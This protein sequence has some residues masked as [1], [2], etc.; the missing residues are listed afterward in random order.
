[1]SSI[2]LALPDILLREGQSLAI[3]AEIF[4]SP[5]THNV[6]SS[7]ALIEQCLSALQPL[8]NLKNITLTIGK[9]EE[10]ESYGPG[11]YIQRVMVAMLLYLLNQPCTHLTLSLTHQT[12]IDGASMIIDIDYQGALAFLDIEMPTSPSEFLFL[13]LGLSSMLYQVARLK[14]EVETYFISEKGIANIRTTLPYKHEQ[15]IIDFSKVFSQR[16][17]SEKL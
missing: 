12:G 4:T 6:F 1:M 9:I 7:K 10:F 15:N 2:D 3:L 11:L 14:G 16:M 8:A 13:D 17:K 5:P